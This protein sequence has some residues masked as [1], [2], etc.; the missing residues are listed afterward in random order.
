[1]AEGRRGDLAQISDAEISAMSR[2][3][4]EPMQRQRKNALSPKEVLSRIQ[5][6]V[7]P[8]D[9]SIVKNGNALSRAQKELE[10]IREEDLPRMKA[11]D[12]HYLL[13]LREVEAICFVSLL[14][15]ARFPGTQGEQGRALPRGLSGPGSQW[16]VLAAAETRR[17][18]RE[19]VWRKVPL[20]SYRHTSFRVVTRTI[21]IFTNN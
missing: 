21:S 13:K 14:L 12:P 2:K 10:R 6:V 1:M 9:V 5:A 19:F 8:Y 4:F 20:A 15:F 11:D 3:V 7:F 17:R 16:S 18:R